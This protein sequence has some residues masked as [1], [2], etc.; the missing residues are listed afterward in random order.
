MKVRRYDPRI[1]KRLVALPAVC[2]FIVAVRP[3]HAD[4]PA[5]PP[6]NVPALQTLAQTPNSVPINYQG[7]RINVN[8]DDIRNGKPLTFNRVSGGSNGLTGYRTNPVNLYDNYGNVARGQIQTQTALPPTSTTA[9]LAAGMYATQILGGALQHQGPAIGEAAARGDYKTAAQYGV[10]GTLQSAKDAGNWATGGLIGGVESVWDA[11][12]NAKNPSNAGEALMQEAARKAEEAAKRYEQQYQQSSGFSD[13]LPQANGQPKTYPKFVVVNGG[14]MDGSIFFLPDW[15][16]GGASGSYKGRI[17]FPTG[18]GQEFSVGTFCRECQ[19]GKYYTVNTTPKNYDQYRDLVQKGVAQA[20]PQPT[21]EDFLLTQAEANQILLKYMEQMLNDNNRNHTE[22]MNAL[23]AGGALNL[24]NTQTMVT[25]SDS[26][27]TFLTEPFTPAGSN[28]AQQ[29]QFVVHNNGTVTQSTINRPDL[30]AN[31]SQAPTREAVG[32]Q[33][34]VQDTRPAKSDST[35]EKPDICAQNPNSLMCADVGSADY[36]DPV[37]PTEQRSLD[38]SPADIFGTTGVCP[39]PKTIG[40]FRTTVK[41]DYKPMCD[42]AQGVRF[43]VILS[44]MVCALYMVY[45]AVNNG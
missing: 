41:I 16:N 9:K 18:R 23:W 35:A 12:H 31:T 5:Y 13:Y 24:S 30:A 42:V 36:T 19:E 22:L 21:A 37:L 43:I 29:T 26:D 32:Q 7:G 17:S 25:G 20:Q 6:Q 45:G 4:V 15:Y 27:N 3:A 34:Q 33:Q 2:L 14:T 44:G 1:S 40:V 38:F 28:Q 39:Q 10:L 11:Y 8:I